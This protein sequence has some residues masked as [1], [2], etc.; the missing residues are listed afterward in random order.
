M[1]TILKERHRKL[2]EALRL[3]DLDAMVVLDRTNT[4]YLT[5][6]ES[7]YSILAIDLGSATFITDPRYAEAAEKAL[8][9]FKVLVQPTEKVKEF[10]RGFF[11]GRKYSRVG[12]ETSIAVDELVQLRSYLR[13]VRLVKA[14]QLVENLRR[15][16][17]ASEIRIIRKAVSLADKLM[18][19]AFSAIVP[20]QTEAEISRA[21]RFGSEE[22]G[23]DRES[24][25]NIVA[26]GPNS[27]RPHHHPGSRRIRKG[28]MVTVDLGVKFGGYC[29]DLTRNACVGKP[30]KK[31][32]EIFDVCLL[33]NQEATKGLRPGMT[34]KEVD[35]IAREVIASAGYGKYFGHG[36]GHGVGLQIHE[37]PRLS[38]R[39][40]NYRLEPGNIVTIE[41]GIYLP[42]VGGVRVEDYAVVTEKGA[43]VLSKSPRE[44]RILRG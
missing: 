26:S 18:E 34:G 6:F 13:G 37:E 42:G 21:I 16:K 20:G 3:E 25:G 8:P 38:P 28:D 7:S 27:S 23:G 32:Q 17:D 31:L 10:L 33:A 24:F 19:V 36:L 1:D 22:I 40:G 12:H 11:A 15:V 44:L 14:G 4:R 39:A 35:A 9:G 2:R 29:S 41:P 5:G 43:T 30:S